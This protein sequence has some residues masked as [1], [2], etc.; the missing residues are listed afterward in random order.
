V[1]SL[2]EASSRELIAKERFIRID[3]TIR[4]VRIIDI[5]DDIIANDV[6]F[7]RTEIISKECLRTTR[8]KRKIRK[9]WLRKEK[10]STC[11]TLS[12]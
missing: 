6:S 3:D 7:I 4:I 10:E 2:I 12:D 9:R 11:D 1:F 5:I 8:L